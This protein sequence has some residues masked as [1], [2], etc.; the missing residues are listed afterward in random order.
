MTATIHP[1]ILP[2]PASARALPP[3]ERVRY[4]SRHAREALKRSAERSNV[5]LGP[6]EKDERGA[7]IPFGGTFWSLTH[8]RGFVGG[9]VSP[10]AVGLD[11]EAI[12]PDVENLFPKVADEAEWALAADADRVRVFFRFWTAKEAVLKTGGQGLA[13]LSRCR[14]AA[15][16]DPLRLLVDYKGEPW[17]VEQRFFA[18]HLASIAAPR[19]LRVEWVLDQ[20]P[21][22]TP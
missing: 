11:I 9:V 15:I 7:P 3:R 10:A 4:L 6:L 13:D 2:V 12:R 16:V 8:T 14:I 17:P 21:E 20:P 19:G 22:A 18:K 5:A 1:V